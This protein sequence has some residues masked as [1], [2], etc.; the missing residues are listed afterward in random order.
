MKMKSYLNAF[1]KFFIA[2]ARV[3]NSSQKSLRKLLLNVDDELSFFM[4]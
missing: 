2:I 3:L 4:L 1:E